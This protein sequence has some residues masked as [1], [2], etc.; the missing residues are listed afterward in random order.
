MLKWKIFRNK[1]VAISWWIIMCILFFLP[2]SA[3][4]G[5][6]WLSKI[7]FDKLVHIGLF[8]VLLFLWRSA[9]DWELPN[10]NLVLL[11]L[12]L[13]YGLAVEF[14]QRYFVSNRDFDLYDVLADTI[15]AMIGLAIWLAS[16][17]KK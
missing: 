11:F 9:F 2:G 5:E 15:G 3:F 1:T 7:Y 8:A 4:P 14:I 12:A 6:N 17:R 13:L 10:Y 16:Y